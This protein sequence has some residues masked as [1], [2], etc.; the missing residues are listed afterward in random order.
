MSQ[1]LNYFQVSEEQSRKYLEFSM[2]LKKTPI[3]QEVGELVDIRASQIN[4]CGFCLDMH[5]K[6]ARIA[7]ERELRLH[8][9]AIWRESTLFSPRE[10]AALAWTEAVTTLSAQGVSDAVYDE[11]RAQLS[12]KEISDLTLLVVG[13][14][15]W[16]RLNVAF[17]TVPGSADAAYGLDKSGLN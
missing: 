12:E 6:Q 2:S 7:G 1:R 14:N 17:R 10:R 16:N 5:V 3:V 4:G 9:I 13:I 11:A 15:G 8:H